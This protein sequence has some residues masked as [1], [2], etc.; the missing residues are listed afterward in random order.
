MR[1]DFQFPSRVSR[2]QPSKLGRRH[3]SNTPSN[4]PQKGN[5]T[6]EA[7]KPRDS[8]E[9]HTKTLLWYQRLGPISHFIVWF[10]RTQ[11]RRPLI[12]QLCTSLCVYLTGDLLAQNIGDEPYDSKRTLRHLT[13]GAVASIPGYHWYIFQTTFPTNSLAYRR[14]QVHVFR[15]TFQLC[16]SSFQHFCESRDP[17]DRLRT[18]F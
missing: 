8:K 5:E 9:T 13:V 18:N 10:D 16:F 2:R 15:L 4:F 6:I 12:T 17:T 3:N 14:I 11:A 1:H 7:S